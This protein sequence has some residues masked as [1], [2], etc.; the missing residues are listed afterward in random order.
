MMGAEHQCQL[1]NLI[2]LFESDIWSSVNSPAKS[3]RDLI[4]WQKAHEF[5]L[6]TYELTKQFPREEFYCLVPQGGEQ[7]FRFLQTLRRVLKNVAVR[8]KIDFSTPLK[9]PWKNPATISSL[10]RILVT[11]HPRPWSRFSRM[12]PVYS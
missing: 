12:F 7:R 10:A 8:T 2:T 1:H 6:R 5:V 9:D 3:F 11:L 4:V